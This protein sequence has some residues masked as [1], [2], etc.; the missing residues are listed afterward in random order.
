M[1]IQ[2]TVGIADIFLF[3]LTTRDS[4]WPDSQNFT[5]ESGYVNFRTGKNY[6]ISLFNNHHSSLLQTIV[7]LSKSKVMSFI[8][9]ITIPNESYILR[10][11][12][13]KM[14]KGVSLMI[15]CH[16]GLSPP[17]RYRYHQTGMA[18]LLFLSLSLF[19][20]FYF[21]WYQPPCIQL[22]CNLVSRCWLVYTHTCITLM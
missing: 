4:Q 10:I 16:E 17:N 22:C 6:H 11:T 12:L 9:P 21:S 3:P 7:L 1:L 5:S 15:R 14:G 8:L 19:L 20:F 18:S 2:C 13:E